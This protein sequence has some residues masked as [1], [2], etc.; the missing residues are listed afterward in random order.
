M[1]G[2]IA[3]GILVFVLMLMIVSSWQSA[4]PQF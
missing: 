4:P 2:W 3:I 1:K